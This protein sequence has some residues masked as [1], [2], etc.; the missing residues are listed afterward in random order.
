MRI[1]SILLEGFVGIQEGTGRSSIEVDFEPARAAGIKKILLLGRNGSGKSTTLN[2]LSPFP[3]QGD[4]HTMT[5]LPGRAGRK[6]VT[7][8]RA[9]T[10]IRCDIRWSSK[11]K[12]ACFMFIGGSEEPTPETAKGN[13][14]EY[15]RAV[16]IEL[17][18]VPDYLKMG[19][20]GSRVGSFLDLQPG[21]RKSF[22]GRFLPEVEEW[23]AMHR[24]V[25]QRV[26]DMKAQLNGL[27]IELERIEERGELESAMRRST[28][29]VERLQR[30]VERIDTRLGAA[31]GALGEMG[32][33]REALIR[34]S[35]VS[36]TGDFNPI[37]QAIEAANREA[38]RTSSQIERLLAERPRL[39][40]YVDVA[41]ANAKLMEIRSAVA[42][43]G[44]ELDVLRSSR[45]EAR[46]RLDA[47]IKAETSA[48]VSLA[49]AKSSE[50]TL[51]ALKSQAEELSSKTTMLLEASRGTQEIPEGLSY[52]DVKA[53]SDFLMSLTGE[54]GDLRNA[55]PS[56]AELDL[57]VEKDMDEAALAALASGHREN[58]RELRRR[59][60]TARSRIA[61]IEAQVSFHNRFAGMHCSD[62]RCPFEK[63]ISQFA[64]ASSEL[65][66]KRAE[67]ESLEARSIAAAQSAT[68]LTVAARAAR[69]VIAAH[70]RLRKH[71]PALEAAGVWSAVGPSKSFYALVASKTTDAAETLSVKRLLDSVGIRRDLSEAER[72]LSGVQERITGL[73]ALRGA[74]EQL[75]EAAAASAASAASARQ[76]VV[77]IDTRISR[78]ESLITSQRQALEL[79]ERLTSLQSASRAASAK[80]RELGAISS[81]LELMRARWTQAETDSEEAQ[82][83]RN[84]ATA[85]IRQAEST[86][87]DSRLRLARRD[88]YESRLAELSGRLER[89]QVIADACHPARGA[90]VEF[91][92]DF[93][94]TT[95]DS[96]NEL[97][98]IAMRGEFRLS[99]SLTDSEF[100]IPVS[101]GSGR[102][103]PDVT[104]ASEGQ[105]ALAKTVLSLAL[106]RQTVRMQGGYN[107]I[108]FDEI[109]GLLDR[110][111]NRERFAEI[112]ER[113]SDELGLEQLFLISHN[114]NF[115]AAPAGLVLFPGHA[116]PTDDRAFMANKVVL[117]KFD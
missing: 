108:C 16:E 35:G 48:R 5:I 4:D 7:F 14:G 103:I 51:S 104:E 57:A 40:A 15:M 32:P 25:A 66:D 52:E 106:V 95:R 41:V 94:D 77:E 86:L 45:S 71:R 73:E 116:M 9:G 70:S 74:Q 37:A 115:V 3:S 11:G 114:D 105:L 107:V 39:Q 65:K 72:T 21:Q 80:A 92:R 17:G 36:D 47:A 23:A 2:A 100:R 61:N 28:A 20:V 42:R 62:S 43:A 6:I 26:S 69:S 38:E 68:D 27:Q 89:A 79:V 54:I 102:V 46:S 22:I 88:E 96:V 110:E 30:E 67:V 91:I 83:E 113:L 109:D 87:A 76:E 111:R 53:A 24:N 117:A 98:D 97:L 58:E 64:S 81:E 93:L 18:V 75:E 99:F 31:S 33:A 8:D 49:Q 82:R 112:V 60:D 101:K 85:S 44:G 56:P 34:R 90:P 55:F 1:K 63:H 10:E 12:T 19:R 13:V 59:L 84:D 78:S 29:E 50:A